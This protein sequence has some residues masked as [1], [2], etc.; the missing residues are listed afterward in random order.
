MRGLYR[1]LSPFSP[2]QSG[3]VSV[4]YEL[5]GM[6]VVCDAGG[7]A[8]NI[9][10]FDEPR[11]SRTRSAVFSAG[12]RDMD[13][14]L[15][16]D[17]RLLGK[18]GDAIEVCDPAFVALV[19]TPVP[20]VIATDYQALCHVVERRFGIAAIWIDTTGMDLYERGE[21]KAYRAILA[22]VERG[23]RDAEGGAPTPAAALHE[24]L[25]ERDGGTCDVGVWGATPLDLPAAD[26]AA[27]LSARLSSRGLASVTYGMGAGLPAFLHALEAPRLLATSPAGYLVARQIARR[28][29]AELEVGLA[30]G[31]GDPATAALDGSI[32]ALA[33]SLGHASRV[34]VVHQQVLANEVRSRLAARSGAR[35]DVASFFRM[36]EDLMREGDLYLKGE[37]EFVELVR[38]RGYELVV[39]DGLFGRA[40]RGTGVLLAPLPHFAVSGEVLAP[41]SEL[42]FLAGLAEA[43]RL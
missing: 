33:S 27:A 38:S 34:L 15:G 30:L 25:A 23:R 29:G 7:C 9:C 4:L 2:D 11:W 43:E 13:A 26:S 16:R 32:G 1:Y 35:V 39:A 40:L 24:S 14:I 12:L 3:A 42:G 20:S 41:A 6:I 22:L 5:G 10:G 18:L 21:A 36:D 28:S 8:G 19:G 31:D 37:N 17:D